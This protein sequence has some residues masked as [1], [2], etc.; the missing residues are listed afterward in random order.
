LFDVVIIRPQCVNTFQDETRLKK[1]KA[2]TSVLAFF[3]FRETGN[4]KRETGN[5]KYFVFL[6]TNSAN[7]V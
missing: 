7:S 3:R 6:G 1:A 2:D 4:G 5:G